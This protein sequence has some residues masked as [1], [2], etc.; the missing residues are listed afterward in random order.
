MTKRRAYLDLD[1]TLLD[2]KASIPFLREI[3]SIEGVDRYFVQRALAA[4]ESGIPGVYDNYPLAVKGIHYGFIADAARRAYK[5]VKGDLFPY[6]WDLVDY[7]YVRGYETVIVSGAPEEIVT[8]LASDTGAHVAWGARIAV[9]RS[10]CTGHLETAPARA[11][12]KR[13]IVLEDALRKGVDLGDCFAMGNDVRDAEM[14]ELVGTPMA[15][16]PTAELADVAG[17]RNWPV[18]DRASVL[19]V[20]RG[21]L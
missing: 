21:V 9:R 5:D 3:L 14:M 6:A 20:I 16:E 8:R 19:D 17:A 4:A 15:F 7:L 11:G 12:E 13:K 1:G 10:R 2:G 18:V